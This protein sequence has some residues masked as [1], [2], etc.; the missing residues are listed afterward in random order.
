MA[1]GVPVIASDFPLMRQIV[2]KNGCGLLVNPQCPRAISDAMEFMI[3]RPEEA[4]KMGERGRQ[5][6]QEH[7]NWQKEEQKLLHLYSKL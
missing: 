3:C 2:L 4:E 7:Y 6:V 1:M 5:A